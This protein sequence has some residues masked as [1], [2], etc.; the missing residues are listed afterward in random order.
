VDLYLESRK[1][2]LEIDDVLKALPQPEK[3]TGQS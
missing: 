2:K 3:K 1:T